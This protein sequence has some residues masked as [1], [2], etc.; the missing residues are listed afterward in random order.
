M[1]KDHLERSRPAIVRAPLEDDA[2]PAEVS[3]AAK[4]A[5]RLGRAPVRI[6][7][8]DPASPTTT[9]PTSKPRQR[10]AAACD[11]I[12]ARPVMT[13]TPGPK[14]EEGRERAPQEFGVT[15]PFQEEPRHPFLVDDQ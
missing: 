12:F 8:A 11:R 6:N 14:L 7:R 2:G 4:S 5:E 9:A 10:P 13:S 1:V 15:L 3:A